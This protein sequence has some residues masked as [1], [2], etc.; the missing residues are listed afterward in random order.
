MS[1]PKH[2]TNK[3]NTK[4]KTQKDPTRL[5]GRMRST[6]GLNTNIGQRWFLISPYVVKRLNR[7]YKFGGVKLWIKKPFLIKQFP[8]TKISE[9][10]GKKSTKTKTK[11]K[12]K[13]SN[14]QYTELQKNWATKTQNFKNPKQKRTQ[15]YNNPSHK[16]KNSIKKK[17]KKRT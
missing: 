5:L 9:L 7:D 17:E 6:H 10:I 12:E 11:D 8:I 1:L 15:I 3:K 14:L 16:S 13:H 4:K 2:N